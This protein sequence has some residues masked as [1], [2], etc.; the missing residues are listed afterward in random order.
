MAPKYSGFGGFFLISVYI[1]PSSNNF[2]RLLIA[3]LHLSSG[4]STFI[5]SNVYLSI[6]FKDILYESSKII[7]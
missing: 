1:Y 4:I 7:S 3:S 6:L 2:I 5:S